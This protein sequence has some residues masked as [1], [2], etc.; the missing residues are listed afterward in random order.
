MTKCGQMDAIKAHRKAR[1]RQDQCTKMPCRQ[2]KVDLQLSEEAI[3]AV[4]VNGNA[5]NML[6]AGVA[7]IS[8]VKSTKQVCEFPLHNN[9]KGVH[10]FIISERMVW[11]VNEMLQ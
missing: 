4:E 11:F 10:S 1:V 7:T 9:C 3:I 5:V 6:V 8:T 2:Q